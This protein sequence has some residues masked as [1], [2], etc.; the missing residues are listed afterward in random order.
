MR[1]ELGNWITRSCRPTI[2]TLSPDQSQASALM[3][4]RSHPRLASSPQRR[5]CPHPPRSLSPLDPTPVLQ[6]FPS[7]PSK[8]RSFLDDSFTLT[9]HLVPAA[10]PRST[11]DVPLPTLPTWSADKQQWKASVLATADEIASMR[12]KQWNGDLHLPPSRKPLWVCVNRYARKDPQSG[13]DK[14]ITLFFAHAN[15]LH[16]EVVTDIPCCDF[17]LKRPSFA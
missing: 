8:Q 14:G 16:K 13:S 12:Y 11:P 6:S 10:F 1:N 15:G 17:C 3:A 5:R 9:T 2:V 7:L 4:A